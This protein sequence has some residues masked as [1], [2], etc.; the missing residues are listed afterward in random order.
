MVWREEKQEG[1]SRGDGICVPWLI[2]VRE[3]V[4]IDL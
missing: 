2:P 3:L 1:F 4:L